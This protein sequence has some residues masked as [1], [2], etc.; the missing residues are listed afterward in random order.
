LE[1]EARK[2]WQKYL[3]NPIPT[4]KGS[5]CR[6]FYMRNETLYKKCEMEDQI[7]RM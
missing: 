6:V 2:V 4:N 7:K 5:I 3:V 1:N